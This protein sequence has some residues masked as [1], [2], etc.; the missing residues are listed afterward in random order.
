MFLCGHDSNLASISAALGLNLPE[1]EN[2]IELHT[3][4]GSKIVFEKWSD[5]TEDY[6]AINLVYQALS[7]LQGRTLLSTDVPPM[8]RPISVEGLTPNA[9]GLY[10]LSVL[11]ARF[12]AAIAEYDAIVDAPTAINAPHQS[13]SSPHTITLYNLQGQRL[14]TPQRGVNVVGGGK[15]YLHQ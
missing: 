9:D 4:I 13:A 2:A 3:P 10:P 5:G 7:Q 8:V 1:T 6:V 14:S 15:K 12:A 11:D